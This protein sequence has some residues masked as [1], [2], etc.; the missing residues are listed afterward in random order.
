MA[1]HTR[2]ISRSL[3]AG[4]PLMVRETVAIETFARAAT[5]RISGALPAALRDGLRATNT[6]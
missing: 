5:V 4:D 6:S 2:F 3:T 1:C